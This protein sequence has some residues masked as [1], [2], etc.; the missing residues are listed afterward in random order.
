MLCNWRASLQLKS[1]YLTLG[2]WAL[3]WFNSVN[4]S[5]TW[6]FRDGEVNWDAIYIPGVSTTETSTK[7]VRVIMWPP[8]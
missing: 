3:G 6:Q 2:D 1:D 5:I 4:P 8:L 7:G